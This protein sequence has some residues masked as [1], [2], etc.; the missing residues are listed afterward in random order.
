MFR[1]SDRV[2]LLFKEQA[3]IIH[4]L[5]KIPVT[6]ITMEKSFSH[7]CSEQDEASNRKT[8]N[9]LFGEEDLNKR[10]MIGWS[11]FQECSHHSCVY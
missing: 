3:E 8:N 4:A 6:L 5:P 9:K 10:E 11:M 2:A 7:L 1:D